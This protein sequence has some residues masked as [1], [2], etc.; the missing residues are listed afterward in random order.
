MGVST[1]LMLSTNPLEAGTALFHRRAYSRASLRRGTVV[2]ART[3]AAVPGALNWDGATTLDVP[4]AS[5]ARLEAAASAAKIVRRSARKRTSIWLWLAP[6]AVDRTTGRRRRTE[7]PDAA[8]HMEDRRSV[9]PRVAAEAESAAGQQGRAHEVTTFGR[10]RRSPEARQKMA[11]QGRRM[12]RWPPRT[13]A[14]CCPGQP[15]VVLR[16]EVGA[17]DARRPVDAR[18][19]H[20]IRDGPFG[21]EA[22]SGGP[23]T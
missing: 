14:N 8:F 11:N 17:D 22:R 5:L 2:R 20:L 13:A 1:R 16:S 12:C 7:Q 6:A 23:A 21:R 15:G 18:Q 10:P 4:L 9:V 3:P 19:L